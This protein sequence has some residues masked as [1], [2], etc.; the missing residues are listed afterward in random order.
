VVASGDK[1]RAVWRMGYAW[2][3]RLVGSA[4]REVAG[5][6]A[7]VTHP[8][9]A[10]EQRLETLHTSGHCMHGAWKSG[11]SWQRLAGTATRRWRSR[12]GHGIVLQLFKH[13]SDFKIQSED[14]PDVKHY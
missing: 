8:G 5:G 1:D 2:R 6:R 3:W 4:D 12:P 14:H 7:A 10:S 13:C 9:P 11:G